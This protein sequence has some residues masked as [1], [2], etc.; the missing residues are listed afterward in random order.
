MRHTLS[1]ESGIPRE[2]LICLGV[3]EILGDDQAEVNMYNNDVTENEDEEFVKATEEILNASDMKSI[4]RITGDNMEERNDFIVTFG[5]E[6]DGKLLFAVNEKRFHAGTSSEEN[7]NRRKEN[8]PSP[9]ENGDAA[10]ENNEDQCEKSDAI[11]MLFKGIFLENSR[12]IM[13]NLKFGKM[14]FGNSDA[15]GLKANISTPEGRTVLKIYS[16]NTG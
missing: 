7:E 2:D 3:Q 9:T 4:A 11:K 15:N 16:G 8:I 12:D 13:I 1:G 6:N 14:E 5:K 10:I